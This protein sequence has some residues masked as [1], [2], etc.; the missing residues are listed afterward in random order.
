[1]AYGE[2]RPICNPQTEVSFFSRNCPEFYISIKIAFRKDIW[3]EMRP[4]SSALIDFVAGTF[5]FFPENL[6]SASCEQCR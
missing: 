2:K 5:L 4:A 1:M 6:L 3:K